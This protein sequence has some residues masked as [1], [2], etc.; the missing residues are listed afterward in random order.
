[1]GGLSPRPSSSRS[2]VPDWVVVD[3]YGDEDY[4][5]RP[6]SLRSSSRNSSIKSPEP[7]NSSYQSPEPVT[8]QLR[9][10]VSDHRSADKPSAHAYSPER[11]RLSGGERSVIVRDDLD[12]G[13]YD[14]RGHSSETKRGKTVDEHRH[15]SRCAEIGCHSPRGKIKS[16]TLTEL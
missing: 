8:R 10:P 13:R 1:M 4:R 12:G 5:Q 9:S 3:E 6:A 14:G 2:S 11:P 15:R 16:D 7:F